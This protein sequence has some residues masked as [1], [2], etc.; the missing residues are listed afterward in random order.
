MS[1]TSDQRVTPGSEPPGRLVRSNTNLLVDIGFDSPD[2]ELMKRV[3]I[4]R[5][6]RDK[7]V[8]EVGYA[9]NE[10][11]GVLGNG[12]GEAP[13]R[14][15][16]PMNSDGRGYFDGDVGTDNSVYFDSQ[17]NAARMREVSSAGPGI[18]TRGPL[19]FDSPSPVVL[20][21][22]SRSAPV[23]RRYNPVN[24]MA[25]GE[26]TE[27]DS[28]NPV[29]N[30]AEVPPLTALPSRRFDRGEKSNELCSGNSATF[31]SLP[32]ESACFS[33]NARDEGVRALYA[34]R[35]GRIPVPSNG[36]PA[37][38]AVQ[39]SSV[40]EPR[41]LSFRSSD[42][43]SNE[44]ANV[45]Y[46]EYGVVPS[47]ND[48]LTVNSFE[49]KH[50]GELPAHHAV[51][52][53]IGDSVGFK[54]ALMKPQTFDGKEPIQSFLAHF[55]VCASFNGWTNDQKVLWLKWALKGRAQQLLWD[56][57][58]AQ[59]ASY[60]DL[61]R[62]LLQR[63]GSENQAEVY[64]IELRN[65][66]RGPR[67][68][69][70]DLM[71]DIRRLMVLAYS[72]TTSDMWESVAM[73]A[74]L[75]ALDDPELALEIRKRG[76]ITLDGA[77]RDALLL[78]G[79]YRASAKPEDIKA[80]G[81]NVRS[82]VDASADIRR[83]FEVIKTQL[84]QQEARHC[85]QLKEQKDLFIHQLQ[86]ARANEAQHNFPQPNQAVSRNQSEGRP[87][88]CFICNMPGHLKRNCPNQTVTTQIVN[89]G[90][91]P[92]GPRP[93]R[94]CYNCGQ[95]NHL[96]RS[97][98]LKNSGQSA[99]GA[100]LPTT[101]TRS[102]NYHVAGARSA[103]LPVRIQGRKRYCLLDTGSEVSVLPDS[104]VSKNNVW[105]CNQTLK[106]ANGTA[107]PIL[108]ETEISLEIGT[109]IITARCLVSEHVSEILLGLSFLEENECIWDFARRLLAIKGMQVSLT[110][111]KPTGSVRRVV[112]QQETTIPARCEM[113]ILAKTVYSDLSLRENDWSS[114][115]I[116]LSPGVRL[117]RTLVADK[118]T[119][120]PLRLI[121]T[122]DYA[123][124]LQRGFPLGNLEPVTSLS[125]QREPL[126]NISD[127]AHLNTVFDSLD[128][129]I[130][131]DDKTSFMQLLT[132]YQS[133]FSKGEHDLG[134]ATAVKHR[135][136]TEDNK[137]VRQCLRRQPP[138]HQEAINRQLEE[139]LEQG[140]I[141][142]SQSEW[143]S[144]IV[145]VKKKDG[146]LRFCVDYRHLNERTIKDSY[147]LPR[148]DECLDCLG[149]AKWF[150][151]MDL[152]SGYHQVAVAED[153]KHKTTFIT[154][155]GAHSFNVMP[156][157]LCNA[158]AT[159]Q[160]LMDCTMRGLQYEICLIY[161]DDIIV[162][163][164]DI[165]SHLVR[166]EKIFER[167]NQASLK[168]KPSKCSFL[169]R[170]VNFLGYIISENG[171][172]T[173]SAKIEA[174]ANWPVPRKLKEVRGF[175]GLCGYYR[176]FVKNFSEIAAPLHALTKKNQAFLWSED[177]QSAFS[178]LKQKLTEAPI[179]SLPLD[180][181][182]YIV[183]TDASDHGIGAILSQ[184]QDGEERVISYAS[185]L[186]SDAEKRY[187][188]TRKELL[189][190]VFFLKHFRQYLL[191]KPFLVRTDHAALQWLRRTPQ[192]IGQQSRWLEVLEEFDFTVEHRPGSKHANADALS[193]RPCRQCGLC[194]TEEGYNV[195]NA[196]E[197]DSGGHID[198]SPEGIAK[199]QRED[200]DIGPI[201]AALAE[202]NEKP[203]WE[204]LL[205]A[206]GNTKIY[207]TQWNFLTLQNNVLYRRYDRKG[208]RTEVLQLVT[209]CNYR[210][211]LMRQAHAGFGGGHMGERRTLEQVRRRAYWPG[212]AAD[213]RR[214]LRACPECN[215]FKREPVTKKGR[216][217]KMTVGMPWERVG[218]DITG[219]HPKSRNG[220]VY[221]LT[222]TDYFTKWADAFP[223]R[224]QEASTV[225][226]ILMDR[227]FS[228]MG[229]PLQIL[230]DRGS[231]F[232][233]QLFNE[234]LRYY[235]I[236]HVRTT[237]YKPSTN[238]QVERFHRTLNSI[239]AKVVSENQRDWDLHLP[240]A[241]A[242]Y[243]ATIHEATGYSPNF[244]VLGREVA[245]PL[246]IV[247]GQPPNSD[248]SLN[249]DEFVQRRLDAERTAY[250]IVRE[251][252]KRTAERQKHYYDLRVK[253][254]KYQPGDLVWLWKSR[255]K[256]GRKTKWERFY[257]GPY[258]VLECL[259]PVNY[260]IR[261]SSRA[262]PIVVHVDKLKPYLPDMN[263]I[264]DCSETVRN[265]SRNLVTEDEA[266]QDESIENNETLGSGSDGDE[267]DRNEP[268]RPRRQLRLPARY[269]E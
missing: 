62:N 199:A 44:N 51:M 210:P 7:M 184:V 95:S 48:P 85:Q 25:V 261:R 42:I 27:A 87:V 196:V 17:Q 173:D 39:I 69:L 37:G 182:T 157:G 175:L 2:I 46:P 19:W 55:D 86:E 52:D 111:H 253:E 246:D 181:G 179:L 134:C 148:I 144:N 89:R 218:V 245:V 221:I 266:A 247:M 161:L 229:M 251:Q 158:P 106:A 57:S 203:Q 145:I 72:A 252:L 121:N 45:I 250:G 29:H 104:Y 53:S 88:V 50:G 202:G 14:T 10:Q 205:P 71:Q 154:R 269:R 197:L 100:A 96:A 170:R 24:T 164:D 94:N 123:T 190:V 127:L 233:S 189:A 109:V 169:Q 260:R 241:V 237:A 36:M 267:P 92:E 135:I 93:N 61:R 12:F 212:W 204:V 76:P 6:A 38:R 264:P 208:G 59:L 83:E 63:F 114:K 163:S 15:R 244:L 193:R 34:D 239:L 226:K 150:S 183:D 265:G 112:L 211:F 186:Y 125:S 108:G 13:D 258:Q 130:S 222:L 238:G 84:K 225:A 243:R 141:S 166:L 198:W 98:P 180:C 240:Y 165:A 230:T 167:L 188:V 249:V 122:N 68:S 139:W 137:P 66:R 236:D 107:I 206:S 147:P 214:M 32:R 8:S 176:K 136:N 119:D 18:P 194:G 219:P 262:A 209:P 54:R 81:Q 115:P 4:S 200:P 21:H 117:A 143:A 192:P 28:F 235:G 213:T 232:E 11:S 33:G 91:L 185:R 3:E 153:D 60:D 74:F 162:F 35:E 56:L 256:T 105:P 131:Q 248:R 224:N 152:R 1:S 31:A 58:S 22:G 257:T 215:S 113:T 259:G 26:L 220:Y 41:K 132:K 129:T 110:A 268:L 120:V 65:R 174:V 168:L 187:C 156:F 201:Y 149:G 101:A 151:T 102:V 178:Q 146:S 75:E 80:K 255:R 254:M 118:P 142:P 20:I 73:N 67:E 77:Y 126:E 227:V 5:P 263:E 16:Y 40:S 133:V 103:Y 49:A 217:Q 216:L 99:N 64:K 234:L 79:F 116:E 228:Y 78:E 30:S 223:I 140:K 207:W 159:F 138:V 171:I 90:N 231:N 195:V 82:T 43:T 124:Q 191:G 172:G 155:R 242:A 128:P 177:C 9:S 70:S 97:C 23:F 160:R 47:L